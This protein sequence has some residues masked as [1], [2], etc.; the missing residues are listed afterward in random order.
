[1]LELIGPIFKQKRLKK[2]MTASEL[3][4]IVG[5][6]QKHLS[7]IENGSKAPSLRLFERLCKELDLK[8][9]R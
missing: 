6:C 4:N 2:R 3:A 9:Y 8:P 7:K 5:C 1:M